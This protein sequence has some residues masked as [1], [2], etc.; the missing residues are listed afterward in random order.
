LLFVDEEDDYTDVQSDTKK[1]QWD[2]LDTVGKYM[3]K[4]ETTPIIPERE[5]TVKQPEKEETV[6]KIVEN[7]HVEPK[8]KKEQTQHKGYENTFL[9]NYENAPV[10]GKTDDTEQNQTVKRKLLSYEKNQPSNTDSGPIFVPTQSVSI[11]KGTTSPPPSPTRPFSPTVPR[12]KIE[13]QAPLSGPRF[14]QYSIAQ[15]GGQTH[16]LTQPSGPHFSQSIQSSNQK[17]GSTASTLQTSLSQEKG[18]DQSTKKVS[19]PSTLQTSLSQERGKDQSTKK[20]SEPST[21]QTSL[22][23]ERGKDQSTKKD[24]ESQPKFKSVITI[25]GRNPSITQGN[26]AQ[27]TAGGTQGSANR[28]H[29]LP[30]SDGYEMA[31]PIDDSVTINSN[32]PSPIYAVPSKMKETPPENPSNVE[33]NKVKQVKA[34]PPPSPYETISITEP[35]KSA[36]KGRAYEE[37]NL[38]PD[39]L[40]TT[41]KYYWKELLESTLNRFLQICFLLYLYKK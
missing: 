39:G 34:V 19:E 41:G 13:T 5:Q 32:S 21:L 6:L 9:Q 2:A 11:T 36:P 26:K 35:K 10:I 12:T 4:E 7:N 1:L 40:Y 23:Q 25:G 31:F 38:T 27:H 14:I 33:V 28:P 16:S 29:N 15:Q 20:V 8:I 30:N 18:K 24:S 3:N 37:I 17:G 22:S